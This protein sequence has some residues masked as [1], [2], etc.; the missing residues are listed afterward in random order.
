MSLEIIYVVRHGVSLHSRSNPV[1]EPHEPTSY[2]GASVWSVRLH[3][4][5]LPPRE[6]EG[7]MNV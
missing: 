2:F 1:T 4:R 6:P 5:G 7:P 3:E